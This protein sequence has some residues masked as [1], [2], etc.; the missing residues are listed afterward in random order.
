LVN[1]LPTGEHLF[2]L[3]DVILIPEPWAPLGQGAG[4]GLLLLLSRFRRSPGARRDR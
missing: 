1:T 3:D 2:N 4:I